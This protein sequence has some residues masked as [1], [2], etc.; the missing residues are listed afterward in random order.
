MRAAGTSADYPGLYRAASGFKPPTKVE[1][2]AV[3]TFPEVTKPSS[4]VDAM[5]KIDEHFSNLKLVQ[6]AGWKTPPDHA[7]IS[8][9][10]E[11]TMLWEQLKELARTDDAAKRADDFRAKLTK[12]EQLADS[13]RNI[14]VGTNEVA[15]ID[16]VFKKVGPDCAICHKKYRNE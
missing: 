2:A 7:D 8:P 5:V 12:A 10:H 13:L 3:K 14:L 1:L 6:K 11:A 15:T 9:T 16:F 4:L